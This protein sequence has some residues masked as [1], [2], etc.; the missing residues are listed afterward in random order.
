MVGQN[1]DFNGTI[2]TVVDT[3]TTEIVDSFVAPSNKTGTGNGESRLYLFN[4]GYKD[5]FFNFTSNYPLEKRNNIYN[6]CSD[7]CFLIKD[8]L[9]DY[10]T[11]VHTEYTTLDKEDFYNIRYT[12]IQNLNDSIEFEVFNQTGARDT[13]RFYIGSAHT[14]WEYIRTFSLPNITKLE[15]LK[16]YNSTDIIYLFLLS[17]TSN[18]N[19]STNFIESNNK[20]STFINTIDLEIEQLNTAFGTLD[21]NKD[22]STVELQNTVGTALVKTRIGQGIFRD[23]V[24]KIIKCCPFTLIDKPYLLIASHIK[25]WSQCQ[26]NTEKLDGYNGFVFTPTYDKLFDQGYISFENNGT[27]LVSSELDSTVTITLNLVAG[28]IYN[29]NNNNGKRDSYLEY[30]R[31]NIFKH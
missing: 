22:I 10:I 26:T 6:G 5:N 11:S 29:I 20:A 13:A 8:N 24:I 23:N 2:Y 19:Y 17:K 7:K 9:I 16:L 18:T 27:L 4:Q 14:A 12:Q 30:H 21:N 28:K 31:N 15:I 3:I 1:I 25:P